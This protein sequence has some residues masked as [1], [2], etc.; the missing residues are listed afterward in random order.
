MTARERRAAPLS[1]ARHVTTT[2]GGITASV[3]MRHRPAPLSAEGYIRRH[4][5]RGGGHEILYPYRAASVPLARKAIL[6]DVSA[7]I[8][9]RETCYAVAVVVSELMANAVRHGEPLTGG[10]VSLRWQVRADVVD[11]EVSD[12]GTYGSIRPMRLNE[13]APGGRGLRIVRHLADEWGVQEDR[14]ANRRTVWAAVGGPSRR[15]RPLA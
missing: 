12:G 15:R 13:T 8:E 4:R 6:E 9:D 14:E 3:A 11:L 7:S 10:G 5:V 1:Y 2:T